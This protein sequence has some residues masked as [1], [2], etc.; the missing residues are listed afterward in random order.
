MSSTHNPYGTQLVHFVGMQL[1][2]FV[3][4]FALLGFL[5]KTALGQ[6]PTM[7]G[8]TTYLCNPT[9]IANNN[10]GSGSDVRSFGNLDI[11]GSGFTSNKMCA[12]IDASSY[13]ELTTLKI[14]VSRMSASIAAG[15]LFK[16][17][18]NYGMK[19]Q[20]GTGGTCTRPYGT[21]M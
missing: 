14:P 4:V 1:W 7:D 15:Y 8:V 12:V 20:F 10:P 3:V 2:T 5:S 9:N 6:Q 17:K 21:Y 18:P 16:L 13:E 11:S 19:I